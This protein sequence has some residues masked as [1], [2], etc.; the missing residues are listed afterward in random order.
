MFSARLW[1]WLPVLAGGIVA[2]SSILA[3]AGPGASPGPE[4]GPPP[5]LLALG[6]SLT[7]GFGLPPGQAFPERLARRLAREGV[8]IRVQNAGVSGDT[9]AEALARLEWL[10]SPPPD[11]VIVELG[12]NDI[13]RGLPPAE[14]ERNLAA[15]LGRLRGLG[16]PVLLVGMRA[17]ANL[18]PAYVRAVD[19]LYARLAREY[20]AL[21]YPFFLEG[22]AGDPTLNLPDGLHPNGRGVE[23]IVEGILPV[24]R[25]LL[26]R[27]SR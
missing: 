7:A 11:A 15:I 12:A 4:T 17:P 10:L 2:A 14:L 20:D 26:G 13:L 22:V 21:L 3:A 1:F 8:S 23:R 18:G 25:E 16:R 24:V 5:L 6:D 9:S 27:L 19:E